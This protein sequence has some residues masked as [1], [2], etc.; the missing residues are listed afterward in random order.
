[1]TWWL[2]ALFVLVVL[3]AWEARQGVAGCSA[4]PSLS[5]RDKH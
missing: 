4:D 5:I 2:A 1:M 3:M